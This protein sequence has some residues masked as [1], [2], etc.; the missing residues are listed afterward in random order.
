MLLA[1]RLTDELNA[2]RSRNPGVLSCVNDLDFH[3]V[4]AQFRELLSPTTDWHVCDFANLPTGTIGSN[5]Q[6]ARTI[7]HSRAAEGVSVELQSE[8]FFSVCTIPYFIECSADGCLFKVRRCVSQSASKMYTYLY[9]GRYVGRMAS[10][11]LTAR[12]AATT[13]P[14]SYG[15][16]DGLWLVVSSTG[17]RKWVYRFTWLG[18]PENMG[19][20]SAGVVSL[21]AA[22]R[23]R[24]DAKRIKVS[25]RN[26]KEARRETAMAQAGKPTFGAMADAL[27]E[28]K[29][30]EWRNEKHK[31][32][33]AMTLTRYAA[34]LRSKPVDE[35]D[36][37]AVL[38]I[39]KP[40]WLDKPETASRL[41]GRIEAVLDA[42]KAQGHRSGENPAAWRGHL[43]HLLPK[44]GKLT[45]GHHAAMAYSDV[46]AFIGRLRERDAVAAMAFAS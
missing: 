33:W 31:A 7:A 40:I 13:K 4:E 22:R 19:L 26:P 46:P 11:K 28:A 44:R 42:A 8:A 35:I 15:D 16:G 6:I 43:S 34:P 18:K 39:L 20:G 10:G 36:T 21:A 45:R 41:R 25:G 37:E 5:E 2:D 23:L 14:G 24:D 29:A 38:G 17:G 27:I 9:T 3:T 1:S 30:A 32:Q 12:E